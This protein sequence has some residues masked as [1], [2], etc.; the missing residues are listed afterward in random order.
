M[1][2]TE[3]SHTKAQKDERNATFPHQDVIFDSVMCFGT[4]DI[5]HPGHR[6]YLS[7]SHKYAKKLI[8]VIARDHRVFAG[9]GKD[10]VHDEV[11]RL[12]TVEQHFPL[13]TV[14]L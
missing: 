6:H 2:F 4:F 14:I 9:K 3:S 11:T 10:P 7:E 5:F 1:A 13:A 12:Q 8:V